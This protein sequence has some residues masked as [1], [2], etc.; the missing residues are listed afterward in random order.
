MEITIGIIGFGEFGKF[1]YEFFSS[2][3]P[4]NVKCKVY[5]KSH[6]INNKK[7]YSLK[8]TCTSSFVIPCPPISAFQETIESIINYLGANTIL[9][10]ICSVKVFPNKI[11]KK[12]SD[13]IKFVTTHPMF[14]PKSFN[15]NSFELKGKKIVITDSNLESNT[16]KNLINL[17]KKFEMDVVEC[18]SHEHDELAAKTQFRTHLI[19][20]LFNELD[21]KATLIDTV[22]YSK[23]LEAL[24]IVKSNTQIFEEIYMYNPYTKIELKK[25]IDALNKISTKLNS[26]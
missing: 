24:N 11:L 4:R 3:F 7:F 19:A 6:K 21:A 16:Y 9:I 1:I 20:Q 22:S 23:L 17:F 15:K 14:G 10:E 8:E 12:Y 18:T 5:S 2:E 13:R 25:V 26:L